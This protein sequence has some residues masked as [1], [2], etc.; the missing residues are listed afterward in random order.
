[1]KDVQDAASGFITAIG[2]ASASEQRAADAAETLLC[3]AVRSLWPSAA[4]LHFICW[5]DKTEE[6]HLS[7]SDVTDRDGRSLPPP[8][9]RRPLDPTLQSVLHRADVHVDDALAAL[10]RRYSS[11]LVT[12]ELP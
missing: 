7:I 1:M 5:R 9:I 12:L 8:T 10:R 6:P 11:H 3:R 2:E 4:T